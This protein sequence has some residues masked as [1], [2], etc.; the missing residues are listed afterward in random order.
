MGLVNKDIVPYN[1]SGKTAEYITLIKP[2]Y[3]IGNYD[4]LIA[5][6]SSSARVENVHATEIPE[7]GLLRNGGTEKSKRIDFYRLTW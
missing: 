2:A 3:I 6:I 1:A 5:A 4:D 7:T